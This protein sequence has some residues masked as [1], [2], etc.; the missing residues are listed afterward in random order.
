MNLLENET[1]H[2]KYKNC[3][4]RG[5]LHMDWYWMGIREL[6]LFYCVIMAHRGVEI[7]PYQLEMHTELSTS[8]NT[9]W[10]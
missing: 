5:Y 3:V 2:F 6:S 8:T 9:M 4:N 7:F 10:A 1:V